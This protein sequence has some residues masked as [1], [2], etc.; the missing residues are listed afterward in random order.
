MFARRSRIV[1]LIMLAATT[2]VACSGSPTSPTSPAG[3]GGP[4]LAVISETSHYVFRA[5]PGDTIDTNWQER[6]HAWATATLGVTNARRITYNKYTSRSHMQAVI[7]V[8]NTNGFA[9]RT[10][11]TIHTLWPIDNHEV[12]HLFTSD[13]GDPVALVNEGLAVAFQIDPGRDMTPRWSGT[14]L[15]D[16][17]RSFRQQSRAVSLAR[18]VDTASW[19]AED[20]NVTYPESGSFMRWL[21]DTYGL[22]RVRGLYARAA[23]PNE[24]ATGVRASFAAIYGR[25]VEELEQEWLAAIGR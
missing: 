16:L 14:P 23:G 5:S 13:W 25:T 4:A 20:P 3:G 7:G 11:F 22:D 18:L 1:L 12:V 2:V 8:G 9:D 15:H 24:A 17:M 19:R 10:T 21:I 6:Y